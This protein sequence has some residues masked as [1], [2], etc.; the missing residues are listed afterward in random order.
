MV[1]G[2]AG[3]STYLLMTKYNNYAGINSGNGQN[4]IAILDP[5]A[6]MTD[7]VTGATGGRFVSRGASGVKPADSPGANRAI[8]RTLAP[9]LGELFTDVNR[10]Y[11]GKTVADL[12]AQRIRTG[13]DIT[14]HRVVVRDAGMIRLSAVLL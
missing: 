10:R 11:L 5:N 6:T 8:R 7:P 12:I 1:P 13:L 9:K 4:K 3:T 14:Q 2:Y